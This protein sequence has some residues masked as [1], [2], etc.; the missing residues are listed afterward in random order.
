MYEEL[1]TQLKLQT[2]LCSAVS[3]ALYMYRTLY[4]YANL[5]YMYFLTFCFL[6]LFGTGSFGYIET[7]ENG[8]KNVGGRGSGIIHM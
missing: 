3:V 6:S 1:C 5:Q 2:V 8:E 4:G 7:N